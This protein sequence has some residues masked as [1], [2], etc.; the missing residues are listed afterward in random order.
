MARIVLRYDNDAPHIGYSLVRQYT[1]INDAKDCT[2]NSS[3]SSIVLL[4]T[5]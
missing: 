5:L 4:T 3:S 1:P 2:S